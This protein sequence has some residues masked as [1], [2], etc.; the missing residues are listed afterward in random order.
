MTAQDCPRYDKCSAPLCPMDEKSLVQ[1]SW[2]PNEEICKKRHPDGRPPW[3][4]T[5]KKIAKQTKDL[6]TSYTHKMLCAITHVPHTITGMDPN[7]PLSEGENK[8]FKKNRKRWCK[9]RS[10]KT[11]NSGDKPLKP[12]TATS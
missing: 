2:F 7:N 3:I 10:K 12:N 5:Q 8:W 4:N 11:K 6:D 1:A 9:P